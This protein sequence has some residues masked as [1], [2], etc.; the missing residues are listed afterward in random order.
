[1]KRILISGLDILLTLLL[2][3]C[4]SPTPPPPAETLVPTPTQWAPP[5]ST[6]TVQPTGTITPH[7]ACT[8]TT[9][10]TLRLSDMEMHE[11]SS[12][13][14]DGNW[15]AEGV[16]SFPKE[17]GKYYTRL[18]IAKKDGSLANENEDLQDGHIV[19][20]PDGTALVLTVAVNPCSPAEQRANSIVRV[21]VTT[22]SLTALIHQDDRLF[23][24]IAWPT[25]V[26]LHRR[27]WPLAAPRLART[28]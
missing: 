15:I 20:S 22:L 25:G 23:T 21:E 12:T 18:K 1:M 14:P 2:V 3:A 7:P 26:A 16:A 9:T 11:W 27:L 6:P 5:T 13:S 4:A 10:A 28:A 8:P 19:W 17:G 24:T